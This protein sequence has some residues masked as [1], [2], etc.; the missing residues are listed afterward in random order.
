MMTINV[1]FNRV[2]DGIIYSKVSAEQNLLRQKSS[3]ININ[4]Q[5]QGY[6][7]NP[8]CIYVKQNSGSTRYSFTVNL[9][10]CGTQFINDFTGPAG[11]AYLEN[12][13]VL[14]VGIEYQK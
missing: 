4:I 2:F 7:S 6:Y 1:E 3:T 12:V 8:E 5:F 9:D 10:S 11:Q 14:Q 13:L